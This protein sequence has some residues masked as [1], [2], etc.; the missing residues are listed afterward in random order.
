MHRVM[1]HQAEYDS[2]RA[3]V[4]RAF[5]LFHI[6]VAGKNVL[7]KPNVLRANGPE[8][9]ITT[10]PAVL[11]AV[12][13]KLETQKPARIVVGDNPGITAYGANEASFVKAGLMEASRG[14]YQNIG[15]TSAKVDFVYESIRHISVSKAVFDADVFISL[16]KFKTH[17]LTVVT[18][19][20]KNSY[21]I[22]PGAQKALLHRLAGNPA[23]FNELVVDVFRLRVPDFFIMDAV[24]GMEGNGP[25][26]T[27]L[28][29][30]G[31]ILASDNAVALDATVARMMGVEPADL[32][33]LQKAKRLGLGDFDEAAIEVCGEFFCIPGF[34]LPPAGGAGLNNADIQN[35]L[36][37]R[38]RLRP[39]VDPDL[40]SECGTCVGQCPMSALSMNDGPPV[41][42]PDRCIACF[43][44]QEMCPERAI[45]LK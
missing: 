8:D 30:I 45:E 10:H 20:I 38:I 7:V 1:I 13:D 9:G 28:R 21:G 27:D 37:S 26:S 33:F 41:V 44:C 16:P 24:L 11:S 25:A 29:H 40:C 36:E 18:G 6:D 5:E 31:R 39:R 42:A 32:I 17:G 14:Y 3:A 35:A 19:A 15:L 23:R 43:C 4:D 12:L 34:K 22:L 2:C